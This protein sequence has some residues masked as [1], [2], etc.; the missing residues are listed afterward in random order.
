MIRV[1]VSTKRARDIGHLP[2]SGAGGMLEWLDRLPAGVRKILIH[3][4]NTNPILERVVRRGRASSSA[5]ASRWRRTAWKSPCE[6]EPCT[7]E[8]GR[9]SRRSCEAGRRLSHPSSLQCAVEF[10]Q[11]EPRADSAAGSR[12]ATTTRSAS[13]SRTP[14]FSPNCPDRA[15]RRNWVQRILDHDGYGEDPGG[16]DSWLRLAEA[17]GLSREA[18]ERPFRR[19][20]GRAVRGRCVCQFR[21]PRAVAG[22]GL[23]LADRAVRARRFTSSG[24][25]TGR[26]ITPGSTRAGL[27]Y[28]QSRVS[29]A[30][31]DVEFG[32]A[33]TLDHFT[34]RAAAGAGARDPEVQ[35]GRAVADERCHG[36]ALRGC[37]MSER[38]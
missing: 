19:A 32:L 33:F 25:P 14:P 21:A 28:F 5:A 30:R 8:P 13:R 12:T 10:R 37:R 7:L 18:V 16:I 34:T 27:K 23:L 9:S 3:I 11:G 22:S 4:N 35:A 36:A 31:R 6:R 38:R 29:L 2:Q 1:G 24:S 17:V 15:V 26:S 20:A